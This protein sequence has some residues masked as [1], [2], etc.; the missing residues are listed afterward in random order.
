MSKAPTQTEAGEPAPGASNPKGDPNVQIKFTIIFGLLAL[1]PFI[2][3]YFYGFENKHDQSGAGPGSNAIPNV[4]FTDATEIS[5]IT[6]VHVNGAA[7]EKLL[8][9]TM[10]GGCA[11]LDYDND[12]FQ[13]ILL[14][15]S[16][17]WPDAAAQTPGPATMALYR[18][19]GKGQFQNVTKAAG[20]DISFYGMGIACG[21]FDND[22]NV[23]VF[24]SAVGMNH[25]FH[26]VGGKFVDI[27]SQAFVGG[28]PDAWSTGCA[29]FDFDRDG[30][31]DLF[32]CNYVK[33]SKAIDFAV[34]YSLDG[35]HRAY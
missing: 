22:G 35:R 24:I 32:V 33:W 13:D 7:G 17:K 26:N 27:T 14:V 6:F 2:L 4:K 28:D 23:D 29:F 19:D 5:G 18:N 12:G 21:D 9:E 20:F 31:L 30:Y 11:F 34:N 1:I 8:P 15:N 3:F 10:G 16:T 25:L